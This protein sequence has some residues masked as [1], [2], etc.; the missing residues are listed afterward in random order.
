MKLSEFIALTEDQKRSTVLSKGVVLAKRSFNEQ[1]IFL[2]QLSEYYVEIFC[3]GTSKEVLEYR[4][5]GDTP[6]LA[7]YLDEIPIHDLINN[8]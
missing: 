8:T 2:F 3:C 1:V 7:L 4:A 6:E 5:F